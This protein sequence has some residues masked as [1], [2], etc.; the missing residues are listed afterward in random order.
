MADGHPDLNGIWQAFVTADRDLQ[1]HEAQAG[2][3]PELMGAYGAGPAGQ[4]I[5]EGGEI[6]Y[7]RWAL[8]KKRQNFEKRMMVNVFSVLASPLTRLQNGPLSSSGEAF[9]W[10]RA[11]LFAARSR[12]DL[13]GGFRAAGQGD[14]YPEV[15]ST[16]LEYGSAVS[17][18]DLPKIWVPIRQLEGRSLGFFLNGLALHAELTSSPRL[19]W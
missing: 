16:P 1:D 18:V 14:R 3:H 4:S 9:P 15:L 10:R 11:A 2:P 8:E 5:V 19:R 12:S 7:Q 13:C 6:P 17:Q